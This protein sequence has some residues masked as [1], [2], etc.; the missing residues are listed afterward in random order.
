MPTGFR[1]MDGRYVASFLS[2][3]QAHLPCAFHG[4]QQTWTP[5][6]YSKYCGSHEIYLNEVR[7]S[8]V[9]KGL[10]VRNSSLCAALQR[11]AH[12]TG[13]HSRRRKQSQHQHCRLAVGGGKCS[14][15]ACTP[16]KTHVQS[17][18]Q[19]R[20]KQNSCQS[21]CPQSAAPGSSIAVAYRPGATL[22]PRKEAVGPCAYAELDA[23]PCAAVLIDGLYLQACS[24]LPHCHG[25]CC[26]CAS[27]CCSALSAVMVICEGRTGP[28]TTQAA[29]DAQLTWRGPA[30]R[31]T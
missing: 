13:V 17:W 9:W 29:S 23:L 4:H 16:P 18:E 6:E 10:D 15:V 19:E 31:C 11:E 24:R 28:L 21:R 2:G 25:A 27:S 12:I 26:A 3:W 22:V 1:T 30:H 7:G 5:I 8:L 14:S 20:A